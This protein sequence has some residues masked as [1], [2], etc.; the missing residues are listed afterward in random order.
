MF[1]NSPD[2]LKISFASFICLVTVPDA[3]SAQPHPFY[4]LNCCLPSRLNWIMR[5]YSHS[6]FSLPET[7][8][9]KLQTRRLFQKA[10]KGNYFRLDLRKTEKEESFLK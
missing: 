4:L 10:T 8:V 1:Q 5:E 6:Y 3:S 7:L 2:R 9:P